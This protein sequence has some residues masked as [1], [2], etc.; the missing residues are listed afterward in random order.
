MLDLHTKH[1]CV[2]I[3]IYIYIHIYIYIYMYYT[4]FVWDDGDLG[5]AT[6]RHSFL[7]CTDK[8]LYLTE[9]YDYIYIYI[10][11]YV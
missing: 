10:H 8:L 7:R 6:S 4:C 11:I 2:Y 1:V 3:Y 5:K 9:V